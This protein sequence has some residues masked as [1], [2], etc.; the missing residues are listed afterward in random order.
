MIYMFLL[1]VHIC[2][3]TASHY[4]TMSNN[5]FSNLCKEISSHLIYKYIDYISSQGHTSFSLND[6]EQFARWYLIGKESLA[7]RIV[8]W[9][10]GQHFMLRANKH[11]SYTRRYYR[12]VAIEYF[13]ELIWGLIKSYKFYFFVFFLE[14]LI[15][16]MRWL[17]AI[18][19]RSN[20]LR[21]PNQRRRVVLLLLLPF[22]AKKKM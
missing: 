8:N 9:T 20:Y 22:I 10:P 1:C 2:K 3:I 17:K 14:Q 11:I 21:P 16:G 12:I 6:D 7:A 19:T 15:W 5:L 4:I 18:Y 13:I